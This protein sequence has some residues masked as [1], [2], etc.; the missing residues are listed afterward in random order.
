M[1]KPALAS[2]KFST[3]SEFQ[4]KDP[5]SEKGPS[6]RFSS[7]KETSQSLCREDYV[8]RKALCLPGAVLI[9]RLA[10]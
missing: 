5:Y 2:A 10:E 1:G 9:F 3:E 7:L 6:K 4:G 8:L